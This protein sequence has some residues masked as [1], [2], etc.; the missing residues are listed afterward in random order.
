MA[1]LAPE[2]YRFVSHEL[3]EEYYLNKIKEILSQ[4]LDDAD[5]E[6]IEISCQR[7]CEARQGIRV[8]LGNNPAIGWS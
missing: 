5:E 1:R 4:E 3:R 2:G 7:I 6:L 8:S